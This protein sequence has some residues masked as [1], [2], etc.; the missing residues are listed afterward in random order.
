MLGMDGTNQKQAPVKVWLS[1]A[2]LA[3]GLAM[4]CLPWITVTQNG[5]EAIKQS[6]LQACYGGIKS[7]GLLI[8]KGD[9][10]TSTEVAGWLWGYVLVILGGILRV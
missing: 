6:G 2:S 7:T 10:P 3:F 4:F 9:F 8:G 5:R 1:P